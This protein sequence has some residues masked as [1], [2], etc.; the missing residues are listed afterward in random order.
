MGACI[1]GMDL[2]SF[3]FNVG[4]EKQKVLQSLIV[5]DE[6]GAKKSLCCLTPSI[7]SVNS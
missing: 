5:E 3:K 1:Y 2:I 4:F 7:H 6:L